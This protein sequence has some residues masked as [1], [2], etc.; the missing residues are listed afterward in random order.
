[1]STNTDIASLRLEL[2]TL[3]RQLYWQTATTAGTPTE[4]GTILDR[5]DAFETRLTALEKRD[6]STQQL[7]DA[8]LPKLVPRIA[9]QILP[10]V[11]KGRLAAADQ[12]ENSLLTKLV[13]RL[14][15]QLT[16]LILSQLTPHL[17][18]YL[19][20]SVFERVTED[21]EDAMTEHRDD[22][23]AKMYEIKD[24]IELSVESKI[25]SAV[26]SELHDVVAAQLPEVVEEILASARVS[27]EIPR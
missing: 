22:I 21:V 2:E 1:M 18:T 27:L 5:L 9:E 7:E 13:P 12:H 6:F 20:N 10:Q 24:D 26:G 17:D 15:E 3:R 11:F 8:L 19:K 4:D 23:E 14:L 25:E 16:P